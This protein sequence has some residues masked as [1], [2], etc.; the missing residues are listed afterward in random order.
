MILFSKNP[1]IA[2]QLF[3]QTA[4]VHVPTKSLLFLAFMI[5]E[6]FVPALLVLFWLRFVKRERF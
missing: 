5:G 2:P 3:V 6:N 1:G 4:E